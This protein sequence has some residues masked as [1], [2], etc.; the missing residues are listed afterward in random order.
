MGD[1]HELFIGISRDKQNYLSSKIGRDF[2]DRVESG[3]R[4]IGFAKILLK[5]LTDKKQDYVATLKSLV[6]DRFSDEEIINEH[7]LNF[8]GSY[9]TQPFG[10]QSYP[11]FLVFYRQKIICLETKYTSKKQKVPVWNSG[12]PRPNGIYIFGAY[13]LRDITFFSG[14]DV[15]SPDET[16]GCHDFFETLKTA[17][18]NYNTENLMAQKYGFGVYSRKAFSQGKK[19]NKSAVINYFEN[20]SRGLLERNVVDR[21]KSLTI[22]PGNGIPTGT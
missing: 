20:P 16:K 22:P 3:L 8:G 11:D 10:T 9:I 6:L 19:F 7:F 4:D 21:L 14:R 18:R 5:D 2:E 1:L 12:L 15:L 13:G 17:E